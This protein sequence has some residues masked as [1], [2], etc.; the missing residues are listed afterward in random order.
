MTDEKRDFRSCGWAGKTRQ[1]VDAYFCNRKKMQF[2]EADLDI[3][4]CPCFYWVHR[5]KMTQNDKKKMKKGPENGPKL[6]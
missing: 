4:V 3:G 5:S 6:L 1:L 2:R